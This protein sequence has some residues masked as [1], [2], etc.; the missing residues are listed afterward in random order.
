MNR[1]HSNSISAAEKNSTAPQRENPEISIV[2]PVKDEKSTIAPLYETICQT[3]DALGEHFEILFID[4]G[5]VDG[6]FDEMRNLFEKDPRV[7]AY[8]FHVNHGKSPAL[9][10]GFEFARG[11]IIVTIDADLQDDPTEI[12]RLLEKLGEGYDLVCGWKKDRQDPFSKR[13]FSRIFNQV[14]A[15]ASGIELHDFNCG[16]KC[17][18]R[19][20]LNQVRLYGEMHRFLPVMAGWYGFKAGEV[21]V[22]HHPRRSGQSKYGGERIVRGLLDFSTVMFFTNYVQRPSHLF[23]R[24]GV[25]IGL[26]GSI[27][28]FLSLIAIFYGWRILGE[29][30]LILSAAAA[31]ISFQCVFLGL[32]AEMLTFLHRREEPSYYIN[33]RLER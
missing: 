19:E 26:M 15:R 31:L 22:T 2:I 33:D 13:F 7:R 4:D 6:S 18:R 24:I 14:V 32:M 28:F 3:L 9:A 12:P 5:S 23:G 11:D 21:V 10:A 17:F 25:S 1:N 27:L 30:G 29:I 16:L 20:V 8:R